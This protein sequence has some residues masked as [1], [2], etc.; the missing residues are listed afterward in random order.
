MAESLG[1][2]IEKMGPDEQRTALV[3][4]SLKQNIE[5]ARLRLYPSL[6]ISELP[7]NYQQRYLSLIH[8]IDG[9]ILKM[10]TDS[11]YKPAENSPE[12]K[13]VNLRTERFINESD[14]TRKN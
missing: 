11:S 9:I 6:N 7:F 5:A 8:G 10:A 3:L 1:Q 14:D 2:Y 13:E 12:L 4:E